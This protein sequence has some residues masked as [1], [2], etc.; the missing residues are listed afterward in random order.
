M[1]QRCSDVVKRGDSFKV[2]SA[3]REKASWNSFVSRMDDTTAYHQFEWNEVI[4]KS[5]GHRV[6]YLAAVGA[7]G[8]WQGVLPLAHMRSRV[9]GNFF[10]S[11]P[12]VNYGGLLHC[13]KAAE[14][15]L[16][17]YAEELRRVH[18][19]AYVELRHASCRIE[20]L[21]TR[22]HKVAMVLDLADDVEDQWKL[23]NGKV[24]NQI[25]KAKKS[26]L[27]F[28]IG[29][30]DLLDSFY[31]VFARNMRDL[32]TPVYAKRFFRNVLETFTDTTRVFVVKQD[33][34]VIAA[35]IGLWYRDRMEVPWASSM[36]EFNAFCPNNLLYW[37]L[38]VFA[39]ERGLSKFDFGRSTPYEGTYNF[40]KQWGAVAIPLFWQYLTE[41]RTELPELSPSN[42]K[43]KLA[44][45]TWQRLPVALTKI[46]GPGIVR[47]IP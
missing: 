44:I 26:G 18:G 34:Q 14:A 27:D 19:A 42:P 37:R 3:E 43:Y 24:R 6:H 25:R 40:K 7:H 33:R 11:L 35:A 30:L 17:D 47:N 28:S 15:L 38:I 16:L 8:E 9:F 10:V 32:G 29:G 12:F 13:N 39:I 23:L 22:Q 21:P 2:L 36:K 1:T 5:F 41:E 4:S 31:A 45:R 46:I 20:D